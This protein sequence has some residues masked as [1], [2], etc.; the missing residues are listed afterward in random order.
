M[1]LLK[2]PRNMLFLLFILLVLAIAFVMARHYHTGAWYREG[3]GNRSEI[4]GMV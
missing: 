4:T 1:T 2:D 3:T